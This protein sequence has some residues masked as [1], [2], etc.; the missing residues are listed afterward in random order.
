MFWT[1]CPRLNAWLFRFGGMDYYDSVYIV[2]RAT[3]IWRPKKSSET[4]ASRTVLFLKISLRA[5]KKIS[6]GLIDWTVAS[7]A[8]MLSRFKGKAKN[9]SKNQAFGLEESA[10]E[11]KICTKTLK[12]SKHSPSQWYLPGRW[13]LLHKEVTKL[14]DRW[15]TEK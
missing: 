11:K 2:L 12:P 7:G 4:F 14:C 15:H 5:G 8:A 1:K 13:E 3:S 9:Q 10:R 6:T